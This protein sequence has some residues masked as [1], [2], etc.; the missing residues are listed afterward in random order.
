M[1]KHIPIVTNFMLG[2]HRHRKRP[3]CFCSCIFLHNLLNCL[4][5]LGMTVYIDGCASAR[6]G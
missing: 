2:T 5:K 4:E 6:K 3:C 1:M